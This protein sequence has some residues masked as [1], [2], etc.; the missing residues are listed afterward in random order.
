MIVNDFLM[1][2]IRVVNGYIVGVLNYLMSR[3]KYQL[4]EGLDI[5]DGKFLLF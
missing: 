1:I 5:E 3:I 4:V 2:F